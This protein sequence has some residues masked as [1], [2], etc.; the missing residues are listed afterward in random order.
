MNIGKLASVAASAR[1]ALWR[2]RSVNDSTM[3]EFAA[4]QPLTPALSPEYRG[5]GVKY[6]ETS[7]YARLRLC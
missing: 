5:E 1:R 2:I 7:D 4:A 3:E 6:K